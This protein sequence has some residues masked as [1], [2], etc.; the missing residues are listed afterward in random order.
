MFQ[1]C[2]DTAE[3]SLVVRGRLRERGTAV[4]ASRPHR[5]SRMRRLAGVIANPFSPGF[6]KYFQPALWIFI[7]AAVLITIAHN[8]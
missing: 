7:A 2:L 3:R 8:I 6:E 1:T 5:R 4:R